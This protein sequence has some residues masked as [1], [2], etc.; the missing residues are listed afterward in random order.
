MKILG[1]ENPGPSSS[2]KL[3]QAILKS[4]P[5][6]SKRKLQIIQHSCI[7]RRNVIHFWEASGGHL[8]IIHG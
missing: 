8:P 6:N 1:D 7:K 2:H 3:N 4:I 5:T